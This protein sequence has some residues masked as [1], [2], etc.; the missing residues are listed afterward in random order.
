M[1]KKFQAFFTAL[2]F[3]KVE[4]AYFTKNI[5]ASIH[6]TITRNIFFLNS[7]I[8]PEKH[9]R[10]IAF[11]QNDEQNTMNFCWKYIKILQ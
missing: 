2:T 10:W 6:V 8:F 4:L 9:L 3:A 7:V 11:Y 1:F 5:T